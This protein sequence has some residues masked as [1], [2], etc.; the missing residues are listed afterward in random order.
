[1]SCDRNLTIS[2]VSYLFLKLPTRADFQNL[3]AERFKPVSKYQMKRLHVLVATS[4]PM[5]SHLKAGSFQVLVHIRQVSK[6]SWVNPLSAHPN[7]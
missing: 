4:F 3:L 6:F 1:M 2:C 7:I 5:S